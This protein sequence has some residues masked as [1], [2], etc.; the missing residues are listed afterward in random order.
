MQ[1]EKSSQVNYEICKIITF[2]LLRALASLIDAPRR[3]RLTICST[4][5]S[6]TIG[7]LLVVVW[8]LYS[9]S[10]DVRQRCSHTAQPQYSRTLSAHFLAGHK[11]HDYFTSKAQFTKDDFGSLE[12]V[13]SVNYFICG[14]VNS[15]LAND[16]NWQARPSLFLG[17]T[18]K[19]LTTRLQRRLAKPE[20][21]ATCKAL[22][23][24]EE[25]IEPRFKIRKKRASGD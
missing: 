12:R 4:G 15:Y 17:M 6:L 13:L 18:R 3:F 16:Q 23:V 7:W 11:P 21:S 19:W 2:C 1:V 8:W 10:F 9:L 20:N 24:S 14:N 5:L 22:A 25:T